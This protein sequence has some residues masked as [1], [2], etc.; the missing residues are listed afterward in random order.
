MTISIVRSG[1]QP[2]PEAGQYFLFLLCLFPPQTIQL[3]LSS[4]LTA[5]GSLSS[6]Q[7]SL[8]SSLPPL[9]NNAYAGRLPGPAVSHSPRVGGLGRTEMFLFTI[10]ATLL[11]SVRPQ[12]LTCP[13]GVTS[14]NVFYI[15]GASGGDSK[16][17]H[18]LCLSPHLISPHVHPRLPARTQ[19]P[20]PLPG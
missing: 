13:T 6:I 1:G 20:Q 5:S 15:I 16:V 3:V 10:L 14:P 11:S 8:T 18:S 7:L 9:P 17:R 4:Q 12:V 19:P 2:R